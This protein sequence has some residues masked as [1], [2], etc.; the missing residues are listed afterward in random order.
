VTAAALFDLVSAAWIERFVAAVARAK[1]VFYTALTHS[2]I[3]AW[4]PVHPLDGAMAAAFESHFG[5]DKGFGPSAGSE[6]T[7]LLAQA[8]ERAG[9]HV[10]RRDSPWQLGN[11]DRNLIAELAQGWANAVL[12]TGKISAA[13]VAA[14]LAERQRSGT[15]VVGH[16][17]LLAI[18]G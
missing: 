2:S 11:A 4:S 15:C 13:D 12:E 8:F 16:E 9:Y 1:A 6:A 7:A 14:W 10:E 17:D 3:A 5:S 18:P